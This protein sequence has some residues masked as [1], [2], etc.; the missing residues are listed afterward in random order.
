MH[1]ILAG[2]PALLLLLAGC[3]TTEHDHDGY[4]LTTTGIP[5]SAVVDQA[6]T[7]RLDIAGPEH[8]SDHIGA[9]YWNGTT[10]D[11]TRDLAQAKACAH[12]SG[13]GEVPGAFDVTCSFEAPGTYQVFGHL[14]ITEGEDVE[15]FW[16]EPRNVTVVAATA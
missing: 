8:T 12:V 10:D 7:F 11:P 6:F 9:H 16:A 5:D 4:A 13:G 15:H 2:A 14:R 3:T 1:R